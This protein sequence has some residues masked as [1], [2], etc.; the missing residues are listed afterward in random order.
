MGTSKKWVKASAKRCFVE[1]WVSTGLAFRG[2]S[3]WR[4]S[5][6]AKW[7]VLWE[8]SEGGVGIRDVGPTARVGTMF[9]SGW[10]FDADAVLENIVPGILPP[11]TGA[12]LVGGTVEGTCRPGGGA[13]TRSLYIISC[14]CSSGGSCSPGAGIG[15]GGRPF[16]WIVLGIGAAF[17]TGTRFF[18]WGDFRK[19]TLLSISTLLD[20]VNGRS[21][22]RIDDVEAMLPVTG[23]CIDIES[24]RG[25]LTM[26]GERWRPKGSGRSGI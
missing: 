23:A 12:G 19:F 3:V 9:F 5:R 6:G 21:K 4:S 17:K 7:D 20:A 8:E 18:P 13:P 10:V 11:L 24:G 16:L 14:C 2:L 1:G 25:L 26:T 22:E 15:R